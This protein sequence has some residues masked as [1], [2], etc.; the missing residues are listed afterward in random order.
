MGKYKTS[1][2]LF[3]RSLTV[4]RKNKKLLLFPVI[5]SFFIAIVGLFFISPILF[6]DSGYPASDSQHWIELG[7]HVVKI[8]KENQVAEIIVKVLTN[9]KWYAWTILVYMISMFVTTFFSVA[10]YN[11]I[12]HGLNDRGVSILRGLKT[13]MSKIK[14]VMIWSLFAGVVGVI[15]RNLEE[16]LGFI[17]RWIM[18]LVGIAWSVA[19]VFVI[20]VIIREEKSSNPLKLLKSSAIMLKKTWGETVIGYL[21]ISGFFLFVFLIT[22]PLFI[23]GFIIGGIVPMLGPVMALLI[24]MYIL[25]LFALGYLSAMA[26]HVYRGALYVYASEGVIPGPFSEELME[27][28]WKVK[29]AKKK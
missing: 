26:N 20:P 19:S 28:A 11:E 4:I 14:L 2:D 25:F 29:K 16:R 12:I 13:A 17:G 15:I 23:A 18:A 1:W 5:E 24:I 3:K 27:K 6:W 10:F 22:F 8:L 7:D 21:G 9:E